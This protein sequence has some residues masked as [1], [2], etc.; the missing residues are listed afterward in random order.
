[1]KSEKLS[2]SDCLRIQ[3]HKHLHFP[4]TRLEWYSVLYIF[5]QTD[6]DKQ[7]PQKHH[8]EGWF[9]LLNLITGR[10]NW[11]WQ[12]TV[13]YWKSRRIYRNSATDL[14][15]CSTLV[16]N[17]NY[18]HHEYPTNLIWKIGPL[19]NQTSTR[20][21]IFQPQMVFGKVQT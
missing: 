9:S 3:I 12:S 15:K 10:T 18:P 11:V 5:S 19:T 16:F 17:K 4:P 2:V 13:D 8:W 7:M 6:L 14:F 20:S 1:M 21:R